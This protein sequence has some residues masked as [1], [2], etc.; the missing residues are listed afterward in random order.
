MRRV[1]LTSISLLAFAATAAVAADLPRSMPAKAPAYVPVGYNWTGFYL[2]INGGYGWGHSDWSAFGANADPS[3]GMVGGTIGYNWQAMGSPYVFGLEGDIDWADIKGTFVSAACPTGCETKNTWLG[4]ARGRLGYA[5]DRVM[6]YITGGAA[7]GDVQANQG[8][9]PGVS[10]TKVGWT[11][12]AGIEAAVF[13]NWTAKVEY[14]Y[15]DLGSVSCG[16]G[17]C[18]VP[19][20]V[21]FRTHIVRAGLNF[22]F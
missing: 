5:F 17:S 9:F 21:D 6:P 8:G 16:A 14:L 10:D 4:T 7:F 3:G 20:N 19:T 22:R 18:S 13:A 2:G 15:A 1:L 11:A 12:G